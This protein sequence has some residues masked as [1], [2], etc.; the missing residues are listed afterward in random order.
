MKKSNLILILGVVVALCVVGIA[1][2]MVTFDPVSITNTK[3]I[4][5]LK[6]FNINNILNLILQK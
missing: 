2:V 1:A 5:E 3:T 4:P 6:L